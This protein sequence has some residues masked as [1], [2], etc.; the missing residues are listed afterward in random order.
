[1]FTL[2]QF[3]L[4]SCL[5]TFEAQCCAG[6][7]LNDRKKVIALSLGNFQPKEMHHVHFNKSLTLRHCYGVC[8]PLSYLKLSG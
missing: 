1:M 8:G 2:S 3:I 4:A 7:S 5:V 6:N